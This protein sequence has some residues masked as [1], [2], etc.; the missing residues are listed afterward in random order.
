MAMAQ[1]ARGEST[2]QR[3]LDE[4]ER[5]FAETGFRGTSLNAIA[6]AAGLGNAGVLHH[7]PSKEKLYKAVLQRLSAA[8]EADLQA[9]IATNATAAARLRAAARQQA[10][11]LLREPRRSRLVLRELLDNLGRVERA[12]RKSVV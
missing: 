11:L 9:I 8:L 1:R 10:T 6:A 7:F 4:A 12:D 2:R 5:Q 3:L